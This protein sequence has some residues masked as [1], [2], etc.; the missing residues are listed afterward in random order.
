MLWSGMRVQMSASARVACGASDAAVGRRGAAGGAGASL[1]LR[2][3]AGRRCITWR[4][5]LP[6][7]RRAWNELGV[8]MVCW[9]ESIACGA[10]TELWRNHGREIFR[11]LL[12]C[13]A[14]AGGGVVPI[15]PPTRAGAVCGRDASVRLGARRCRHCRHRAFHPRRPLLLVR[16]TR[17]LTT[18][19]PYR[20]TFPEF[21]PQRHTPQRRAKDESNPFVAVGEAVVTF[22]VSG[23]NPPRIPT[24]SGRRNRW[25]TTLSDV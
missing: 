6:F 9:R 11:L 5:R 10:L 13:L 24:A 17:P 16:L 15:A 14:A 3:A 19:P 1:W 22:S 2:S 21:I 12:C 4:C 20:A 25:S 8:S 18:Q 23:E 7:S